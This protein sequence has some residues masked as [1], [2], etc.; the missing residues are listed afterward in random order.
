MFIRH[1]EAIASTDSNALI[2]MGRSGLGIIR[3]EQRS[4]TDRRVKN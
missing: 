1:K 2:M 4:S 3:F